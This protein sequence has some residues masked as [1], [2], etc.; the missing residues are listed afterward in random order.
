MRRGALLLGVVVVLILTTGATLHVQGQEQDEGRV[1]DGLVVLYEFDERAGEV[2]KDKSGVGDPLNLTISDMNGVAWLEGGGLF[3][4]GEG[5]AIRTDEAATKIIE[6]LQASNA[7]TIEAVV[8]PQNTTQAGPARVVSLSRDSGVR[9]FTLGQTRE[10]YILRLRTSETD[11]QGMPEIMTDEGAVQ[12]KR[13]HVVVT[14]DG[15]YQVFVNVGI[16]VDGEL[17]G[18]GPRPGDFATWDDSFRFILANEDSLDR[19]WRGKIELVAIY[20]RALSA[21]EVQ[22][23]FAALAK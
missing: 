14:Y 15:A 22:R 10:Q 4:W 12:A 5:V 23:N 16:F 8:T 3:V 6:A 18:L 21:E 1:T 20:G 2:V 19:Q 9:N 7:L 11:L 13:Q 17:K